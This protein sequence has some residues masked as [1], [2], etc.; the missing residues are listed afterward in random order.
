MIRK[1][2]NIKGHNA[3]TLSPEYIGTNS[4]GW[5]ITGETKED[6]LTWVNE[7]EAQH[8]KFGKV[9]GDFEVTVF[10]DSEEGYRHFFE[11]HPPE[12]WDYWDI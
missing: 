5:V 3:Y 11:N 1:D 10:A 6:Y 4:S 9:W 8:P 7:F 2:F 12:E